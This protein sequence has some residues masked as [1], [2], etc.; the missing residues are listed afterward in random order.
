MH[1]NKTKR[2]CVSTEHTELFQATGLLQH[3]TCVTVIS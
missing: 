3:T 2:K 1:F